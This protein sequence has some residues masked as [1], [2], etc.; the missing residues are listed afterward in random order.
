MGKHFQ[1]AL[2]RSGSKAEGACLLLQ[3]CLPLG[4]YRTSVVQKT[5][6]HMQDAA[7]AALEQ[8]EDSGTDLVTT[9]MWCHL[10]LLHALLPPTPAAPED[11]VSH[12]T[13]MLGPPP[14]GATL[15]HAASFPAISSQSRDYCVFLVLVAHT[16]SVAVPD[17]TVILSC[18]AGIFSSSLFYCVSS[19]I[20]DTHTIFNDL[21]GSI[22]SEA[23]LW[24]AFEAVPLRVWWAT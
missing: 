2:E 1:L 4:R 8:A 11:L 10:L 5:V 23:C 21:Q 18:F 9:Q 24:D 7:A 17:V 20:F 3:L 15:E 19:I 16:N 13:L 12:Q 22:H 14:P 6:W